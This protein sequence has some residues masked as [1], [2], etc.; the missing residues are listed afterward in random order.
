M[1]RASL[2][3][4]V[5]PMALLA[6]AVIIV[7]AVALLAGAPPQRA[8]ALG[9]YAVGSFLAIGGFALGS[10]NLFRSREHRLSAEKN[11][12]SD[13]WE[14]NEAAALL[15]VVGLVLLTVGTAVDPRARLI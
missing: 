3:R 6:C 14:T 7:A 1:T 15:I 11:D 9:F 12:L 5:L 13:F 4:A 10:R 8:F 2:R